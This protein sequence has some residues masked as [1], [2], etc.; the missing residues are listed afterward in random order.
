MNKVKKDIRIRIEL[1]K[2]QQKKLLNTVLSKNKILTLKTREQ[3]ISDKSVSATTRH[4]NYCQLTGRARGVLP[5]WK[6]SRI[7]FK[8][9]ADFGKIPGIRKASW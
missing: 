3:W 8:E 9:N 5:K 6:V 4:R 7:I 2:T 1:L